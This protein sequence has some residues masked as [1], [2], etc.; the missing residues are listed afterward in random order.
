MNYEQ[1]YCKYKKKYTK[2]LTQ[3][4]GGT[5]LEDANTICQLLFQRV[6]IDKTISDND[7]SIFKF[8]NPWR[9]YFIKE[10]AL[11]GDRLKNDE[12]FKRR[13]LGLVSYYKSVDDN[14]PTIKANNVCRVDMSPY[15]SQIYEIL[16][17]F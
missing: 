2:L 12:V 7:I 17:C 6:Q 16:S 4:T 9:D 11:K 3:Q 8:N 10:D 13:I 15:Q 1:K 5:A 14:Y